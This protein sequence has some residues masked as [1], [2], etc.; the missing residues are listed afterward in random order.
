[1]TNYGPNALLR[2]NGDGS[3]TDVTRSAGVGTPKGLL[4]PVWST[5]ASWADFDG[6]GRLDLFVANYL[7]YDTG[8]HGACD[9]TIAGGRKIASYC[10]PHRFDGVP[11]TLYRN[12]GGGRFQDVSRASGIASASGWL[13][14][15]GLGVVASD[16]DGDGACFLLLDRP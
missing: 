16:F 8:R 6:D 1:M 15:K 2:N 11:D 9:A 5:S 10:H 3:F 12:L 13:E 4:E 7:A 14:A